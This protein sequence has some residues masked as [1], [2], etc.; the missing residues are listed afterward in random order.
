MNDSFSF[1]LM[2]FCLGY[3]ENHTFSSYVFEKR[4]MAVRFYSILQFQI[5]NPNPETIV[6][7]T[8][9]LANQAGWW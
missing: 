3:L 8:P 6:S 9:L 5:L 1:R 2:D 7:P 4:R